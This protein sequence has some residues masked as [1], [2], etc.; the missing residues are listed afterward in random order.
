MEEL[1]RVEG[2]KTHFEIKSEQI[3][4][5]SAILKAVDD[6][7]F[8]VYRGEVLGIV[9]ESGCGK[10]TLART[11]L[12]LAEKTAGKVLYKASEVFSLS[13]PELKLARREM[14][15]IFQDPFSSLNPRKKVRTMIAQPLRIYGMGTRAEI[16]VRVD[17]LME[18]VGLS[19]E[20]RN[21]YP[22][23][24]S[25]GQRQR[26]G[27]ARALAL[28]PE[29][30]ACD[31]AVSALDV[32]IQAQILNLLLDLRERYE[33]TYIFIAHDL[34]VVQ[35]ISTRILVMY[36]GR[37]VEQAAKKLLTAERL[38]PY[39]MA[40][41]AAYPNPDP[42]RREDKTR[43]VMGDVPSPIRPPSGCHFHPRCPHRMAVCESEYPRTKEVRPGHFVACHLY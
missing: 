32:S 28:N 12:R 41:F 37:I 6:V 13:R 27:I 26:I 8:S 11:I 20:Y 19:S 36:L 35:F 24:F 9:G 29:F 5:K 1:I 4:G 43:V 17:H 10:S 33:L 31:E 21:R 40:L 3:G 38:H 15:M 34:S 16:D 30:I 14:Q 7:S 39:T 42:D 23:Q 18:E 25:G 22:H 2:L